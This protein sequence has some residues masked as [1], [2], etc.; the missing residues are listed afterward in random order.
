[1]Q[2]I[3]DIERLFLAA[4]IQQKVTFTA[5]LQI[6]RYFINLNGLLDF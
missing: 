5:I 4:K 3:G 1:M 2:H 6:H